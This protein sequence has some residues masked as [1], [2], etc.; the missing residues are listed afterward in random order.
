MSRRRDRPPRPAPA[1]TLLEVLATVALLGLVMATCLAGLGG[2]LDGASQREAVAMA[3]DADARARIAARSL[4]AVRVAAVDDGRAIEVRTAGGE[5]LVR[6]ELPHGFAA[7]FVAEDGS[8]L[9]VVSVDAAGRSVDHVVRID[10]P[11]GGRAV[12][13]AGLTG[14]TREVDP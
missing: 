11:R 3:R 2:V 4:G 12:R 9:A 13:V 8:A 6:R 7:R 14:W 1:F 5:A 10:G